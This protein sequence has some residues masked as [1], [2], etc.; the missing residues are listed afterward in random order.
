VRWFFQQ[1]RRGST[2]DLSVAL[3]CLQR[4]LP[5]SLCDAISNML[6]QS[7]TERIRDGLQAHALA[8]ENI[9]TR[10]ETDQSISEDCLY[11]RLDVALERQDLNLREIRMALDRLNMNRD[12]NNP[13]T[14]LARASVHEP[15]LKA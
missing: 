13:S 7:P 9:S 5:S 10:I 15:Y 14:T 2:D 1:E 12:E 6:E 4:D 11:R 8:P 3:A